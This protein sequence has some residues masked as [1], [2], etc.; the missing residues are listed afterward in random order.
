MARKGAISENG[1]TG[2]LV[3]EANGEASLCGLWSGEYWYD[4]SQQRTRFV[5]QLIETYGALEG[6]TLEQVQFAG[7]EELSALLSGARSDRQ[8]SFTKAYDAARTLGLMPVVYTGMAA[9]GLSEMQGEW[10]LVARAPLRGGFAMR[11]ISTHPAF[12]L[13]G[14]EEPVQRPNPKEK[15]IRAR[16]SAI[17]QRRKQ[18]VVVKPR[19]KPKPKSP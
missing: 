7:R 6:V 2:V 14:R 19:R 3:K 1:W 5:A 16:K 17:E 18:V 4:D 12:S 15:E 13:R 8:V 11:R 10:R 9:A